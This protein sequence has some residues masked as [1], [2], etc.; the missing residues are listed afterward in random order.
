MGTTHPAAQFPL[1]SI[2]GKAEMRTLMRNPS[3][4]ENVNTNT[5]AYIDCLNLLLST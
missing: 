3:Q 4:E 2:P 1:G 5:K